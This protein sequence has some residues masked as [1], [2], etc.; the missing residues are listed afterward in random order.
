MMALDNPLSMYIHDF[1]NGEEISIE[2]LLTLSSGIF[3]YTEVESFDIEGK[4]TK[5]KLDLVEL[6]KTL[7]QTFQPGV[8][9]EYS[10]SNYILL[11][12]IIEKVS[13]RSFEDYL[14]EELLKPYGL[15][16]TCFAERGKIIINR[17]F[18]YIIRRLCAN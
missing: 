3:D 2:H 13:R 6:I 5:S 7:P 8:K 1:P 16:D 18:G 14:V 10:N 17:S 15:L 11:S 4:L 9:W 12:Y